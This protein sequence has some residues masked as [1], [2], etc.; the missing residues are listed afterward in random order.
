MTYSH[1]S[2]SHYFKAFIHGAT[3]LSVPLKI[4]NYRSLQETKFHVRLYFNIM[5]IE[6]QKHWH[7]IYKV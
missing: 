6:F 2:D 3:G 1:Y 4:M 7:V 5:D